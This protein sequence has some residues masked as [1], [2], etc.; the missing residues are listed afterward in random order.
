MRNS[1][2]IP[3]KKK[4]ACGCFDYNF[5]KNRCKAHAT[6]AAANK[7]WEAHEEAESGE[8]LQGL[9]EDLD[10]I[11]SR[12]IRLKYA[13]EKGIVP[14]YTCGAK[15]PIAAIQNGHFVHRA[16]MATR[17]MDANC[18]PQCPSCNYAHNEDDTA[19]RDRLE[20]ETP[21][22]PAW[23]HEQARMVYKPTRDELR[24]LMGEYRFKIKALEV[25]RKNLAESKFKK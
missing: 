17:F 11:F 10:A 23:L 24:G 1:T 22:L 25:A 14:C 19:F 20:R 4:L 6:Q 18:R 3:K 16:D 7:R 5:S 21:G 13:D 12:Y 2:I 15:L 8:S 9:V